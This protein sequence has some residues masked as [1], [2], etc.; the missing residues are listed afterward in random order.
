MCVIRFGGEKA[1]YLTPA[2]HGREFP[3]SADYWDGN[4]LSCTAEVRVS[5]FRG[6]RDGSLRNEELA[7]FLTGLE[8]VYEQLTGEA[9]F[10][11]MERW[12]DVRVV[13]DGRGHMEARGQ[14]W[15]D[16]VHDH[17]LDFRL[18]FDQTFL[19]PIMEQVRA[20]LAAFPLVGKRHA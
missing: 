1:E 3:G 18:F 13:G 4:W 6:R 8:E 5:T 17:T 16:P 7:R 10:E 19:P 12:L 15:D 2:V 20:V 14:L 11:T 9:R